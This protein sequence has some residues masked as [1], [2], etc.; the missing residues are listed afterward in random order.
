MFLPLYM[1]MKGQWTLS[2]P[3]HGPPPSHG[4]YQHHCRAL[5]HTFVATCCRFSCLRYGSDFRN[6]P[7]DWTMY[8]LQRG[9]IQ[10]P[11]F[12]G[13]PL[14]LYMYIKGQW[15][16]SQDCRALH[17]TFVAT[18][19]RFSCLRLGQIFEI[20]P[21]VGQCMAIAQRHMHHSLS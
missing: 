4:H 9:G 16:L 11:S 19:W 1:Y 15:A 6:R 10:S 12:L 3:L 2:A 18:C 17:H 5:H 14:P 13:C 7:A 8:H 21:A 20:E